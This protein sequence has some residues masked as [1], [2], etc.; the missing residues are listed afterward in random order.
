[1]AAAARP[2][3]GVGGAARE[4]LGI[5]GRRLGAAV[6]LMV[7]LMVAALFVGLF[8]APVSL[9]MEVALAGRPAVAFATSAFLTMVQWFASAVVG[10]WLSAAVVALVRDDQLRIEQEAADS[11]SGDPEAEATI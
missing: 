7:C 6:V 1:M 5:L 11:A 4:S 3:A 8:F 2:E 10:A 9:V